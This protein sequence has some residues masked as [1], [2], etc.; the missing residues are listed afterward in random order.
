VTFGHSNNTVSFVNHTDSI[1]LKIS[2]TLDGSD[3]L[4]DEN[5]KETYHSANGAVQ[6]SMHVFIKHGLLALDPSK[7]QIA[8]FEM[9]FGTGLNVLMSLIHQPKHVSVSYQSLEAF[10][11][12]LTILK[13]LNYAGLADNKEM[14]YNIV[15]TPFGPW[16]HLANGFLLKKIKGDFK[17]A[18]ISAGFFDLIYY[19]AF[20]PKIQ[21]ELWTKECMQKCYDLLK[22]GGIFVTYCAQGEFKRNLKAVGFTVEELKGPPGKAQMTRARKI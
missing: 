8:V 4:T 22:P 20:G 6:E 9:G 19:D 17:T 13:Q 7:T 3:T 2:Q 10:P 1:M 18:A 11:V 15:E 16:K 12:D 5:L 21:P 14:Y